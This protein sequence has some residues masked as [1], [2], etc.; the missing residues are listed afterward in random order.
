MVSIEAVLIFCIDLRRRKDMDAAVWIFVVTLF[1]G[2]VVFSPRSEQK[3]K[4]D[5]E[6]ELL[7][8]LANFSVDQLPTVASINDCSDADV[9]E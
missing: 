7:L 3:R 2:W 1:L 6:S 4:K 8:G 9:D 5:C